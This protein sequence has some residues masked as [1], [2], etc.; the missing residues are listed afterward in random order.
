MTWLHDVR[1]ALRL[2][3]KSPGAT[4]IAVVT[5]AFGIGATTAVFAVVKTVLLE[6]VPL[7]DGGM[8]GFF[9]DPNADTP[10]SD[11]SL[12]DGED[13]RRQARS[14]DGMALFLPSWSF[15]LV[16]EDGPERVLGVVAETHLF[17][18]LRADPILGR[19]YGPEDDQP[20][21]EPVVVIRDSFWQRRFGGADDVIGRTIRLSD[22]P[23]TIIGVMPDTFDVLRS[24]VELW[25]PPAI[26]TPWALGNRG[27][28]NFEAI[29]RLRPGIDFAE[30]STEMLA[31]STQLAEAYP[32]TN[33]G[34]L[35]TV[36]PLVH[37]LVGDARPI[38]L[39]LFGAV[40]LVLLV[41]CTNLASLLLARSITRGHE[42]AT[43]RALGASSGRIVRQLV[44]EGSTLAV[45]GGAVGVLSAVW[46]KDLLVSLAPASIP[47]L[48][49]VAVDTGVVTFAALLAVVSGIALG[50]VP[51]ISVLR[52]HPAGG[53]RGSRGTSATVG[54]RRMLGGLVVAEVAIAC[55]LL[56]G[57][58]L[59]LRSLDQLRQVD[60]GFEREGVL[61]ADIVLPEARY[62]ERDDQ[63]RAFAAIVEAARAVPGVEAVSTVIGAPLEPA[64]GVGSRFEIE[65][66]PILPTGEQPGTRVRPILGDHF[67]ALRQPLIEGRAFTDRDHA[68]AP[69]VAIL[70]QAIVRRHWPSSSPIGARVR[71]SGWG[72][73]Q[74]WRTVVGVVADVKSSTLDAPDSVAIYTPY[75]QRTVGWQRFGTL[76]ARSSIEPMS[77]VG[78][79]REAVATVDPALPLAGVETLEERHGVALA[80]RRLAAIGA[81]V[82]AFVALA[83]TALG[84]Y[85]TL[86]FAVEQRRPELG[87]R[88]ALGADR[89]DIVHGVLV[90]GLRLTA[91]GLGIGLL[92]SLALGRLLGTLLF[93]VSASD[94]AS[95]LVAIVVLGTAAAA[96]GYLPG[97]R[98]A[99]VDPIDALREA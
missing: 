41:T 71:L 28:N 17:A 88:Q 52:G 16:G 63:S 2:L 37:A 95:F 8:L 29:A 84:V 10:E 54:G 76:V 13:W 57:G 58:G 43:R 33:R 66:R 77:I 7:A 65:G 87:I 67:R 4:A 90:D 14:F 60:L 48:G 36:M 70:N 23:Y 75:L 86:A 62:S 19:V 55:A 26:A 32:D 93:E 24:G 22:V 34:K 80:G 91:I 25:V 78:A 59:L 89:R 38:L 15:D 12:P 79:V 94:P 47:R 99:R 42:L 92:L 73:D 83:L 49:E 9:T 3:R 68:T 44:I 35:V 45:L 30:A 74:P 21:A 31:L 50:L 81:A 51:A 69:P 5:L 98:A 96:A 97:R 72:D 27:T 53:L 40:A 11:I 56:V 61:V 1:L 46:A 85:G 18:V 6:P 20:G 64:S 82:F 39:A